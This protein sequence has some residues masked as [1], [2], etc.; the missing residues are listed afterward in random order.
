MS[1]VFLGK[2]VKFDFKNAYKLEKELKD[3]QNELS[4]LNYFRFDK[5]KNRLSKNSNKSKV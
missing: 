4:E 3:I 1:L 5:V 2:A